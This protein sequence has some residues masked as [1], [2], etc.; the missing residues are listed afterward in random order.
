[1]TGNTES[2]RSWAYQTDG[3]GTEAIDDATDTTYFFG[4]PDTKKDWQL[5]KCMKDVEEYYAANSREP[6]ITP[7]DPKYQT[8]HT[9]FYPTTAQYL[10]W[11]LKQVTEDGGGANIHRAEVLDSGLPLPITIRYDLTGGTVDRLVQAVDCYC[12][13]LTCFA[14]YN[15]P[16]LVE[17]EWAFGRLED[18][19]G[20]WKL[21]D[22]VSAANAGAKTI[23]LT[24]TTLTENQAAG[25]L[26]YTDSGTGEDEENVV[27]SNTAHATIPVLTLTDTP[28]TIATDTIKL[29]DKLRPIL[30]TAPSMPGTSASNLY[31]GTPEVY[32]DVGDQNVHLPECWAANW[33][34]K[35]EYE[36]E[37]DTDRKYATTYLYTHKPILL[38]LDIVC[39][40]HKQL[41]DYIDRK[42]NQVN[43]KVY[44]PN[45]SYYIL[46]KFTNCYIIDWTETGHAYEGT[47]NVK[48]IMKAAAC[49]GDFTLESETNW[50]T[51]YK[52]VA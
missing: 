34:H 19:R 49:T 26:C 2:R 10:V 22:T 17:P 23:T 52:T 44:K 16:F 40:K 35:Q 47:Y 33:E 29:F 15:M 6:T 31:N 21:D 3:V 51:H 7:I 48:A 14:V 50:S 43:I 4:L 9:S 1:M 8:F 13:G 42:A 5:P 27:V 12:V 45:T 36:Q 11:M 38:T 20:Q 46:H 32:W 30:T 39:E 41:Y 37:L 18:R 25:W 24:N 28:T